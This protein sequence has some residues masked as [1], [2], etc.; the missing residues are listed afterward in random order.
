MSKNNRNPAPV[1]SIFSRF[2]SFAGRVHTA[3]GPVHIVI[4]G[5][6]PVRAGHSV[7]GA[8]R[9]LRLVA[10]TQFRPVQLR[11]LEGHRVDHHRNAGP[12]SGHVHQR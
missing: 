12:D 10:R 7:P 1:N 6:V 11:T 9:D 3:I 8:H 4:R 2:Y 5:P